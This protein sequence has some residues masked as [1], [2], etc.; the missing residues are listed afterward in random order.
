MEKYVDL[1]THSNISDGSMT[2]KELVNCAKKSGL[3]AIALTDHDSV[4]GV[5][6]AMDEGKRIGLEVLSG[7]ELSVQSTAETHILGYGIDIDNESLLLKL[8]DV[9]KLRAERIQ[10]TVERLR[11][12]E[13][14]I[15]MEDVKKCSG[16]TII[17]RAHIARAMTEKGYTTSIKE[18]F[19]LYLSSGKSAYINMQNLTA[20]EGIALINNADGKAFAAHLHL[21]KKED[22][23]LFEYLKYLKS[24]GLCGIEGYYTDYTEEMQKKYMQMALD[25]NLE[26]SGGTDFH[27]K[28]KPHITI[29]VGYG[30][31]KIPYRI[32]EKLKK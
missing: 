25:L 28:M 26:I 21:M 32:F 30:N 3:A 29:G 5:K 13:F 7:I 22:N 24:V 12:L 27:G 18:A 19:D 15:T 2:P 6:E 16:G 20:E 31:L 8:E 17:G 10:K 11:E 1:H 14:D 23:E 9:K 4:A